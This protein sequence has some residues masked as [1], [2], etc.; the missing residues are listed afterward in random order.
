MVIYFISVFTERVLSPLKIVGIS[1]GVLS[2]LCVA[3]FIGCKCWRKK[4][5]VPH[6]AAVHSLANHVQ[7]EE[8]QDTTL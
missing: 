8:E 7:T 6:S 2:A 4:N 5:R 1:F 3:I